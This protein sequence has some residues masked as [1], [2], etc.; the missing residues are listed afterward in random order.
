MARIIVNEGEG[1]RP[2]DLSV[3][4]LVVGGTPDCDLR[5]R[6]AAAGGA[7]FVIEATPTGHRVLR[8]RGALFLN[9]DPCEVADLLH[10]DTLRA[11]ESMILYKN[12][13]ATRPEPAPAAARP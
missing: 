7:E 5:L 3:S 13:D 4:R 6:H 11:G 2:A 9:E 8:L 12:P 10:N 1:P